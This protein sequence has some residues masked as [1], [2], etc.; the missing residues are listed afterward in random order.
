MSIVRVFLTSSLNLTIIYFV[1]SETVLPNFI[2]LSSSFSSVILIKTQVSLCLE[3]HIR[4]LY[5]LY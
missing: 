5:S 3:L 1:V 4:E 2:S